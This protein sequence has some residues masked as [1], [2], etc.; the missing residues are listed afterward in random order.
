LRHEEALR[1]PQGGGLGVGRVRHYFDIWLRP[2]VVDQWEADVVAAR[3]NE[4]AGLNSAGQLADC[5]WLRKLDEHWSLK[6]TIH[7]HW[8]VV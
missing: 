4:T 7:E 8:F 2:E 1:P 6:T 5:V 3:A